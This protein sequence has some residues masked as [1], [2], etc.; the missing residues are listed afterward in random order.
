MRYKL[1]GKHTGLRVS[2]LVL[3]AGNFGTR[4][5]HGAEPDE[6]RRIFDAYAEAGGNFIDTANG[7]QFGQSEEI[8]GDLLAGKRDD[9]VLATKFTMRTDPTSGILTTGNSRKSM[10][11]SV[12]ASLKRLK[13]DRVDVLWAH[14][15]D[16]VTP[17]EELVRGFDD[18]VRAGKVLYAGLSDFPAWRV[19]R[20]ATI[21]ELRGVAPIAGLQVE[22]SLVER[23]TEQELLP[24][25]QALGLGVVAWSPLGG[26]MLT[27]KYRQGEKGRAEGFGGRVFQAENSAQRTAILDTLIAVAKDAGVTPAEI[28]IAWV[29]SKGSLPVIGPRT[30]AQLE[31]NL[32]A[33]NVTL[34]SEQIARLDEVSA[35]PPVFPYTLLSDPENQQGFT[36]GKLDLFDAPAQVVA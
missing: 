32:S 35:L 11:S 4:W 22:H 21:A 18:L 2:E 7:Y 1:F 24:A 28:A 10:I 9:F 30:V 34:S 14:M 3:G 8:L 29:A 26:G 19:A 13:T 12:E 6:A 36:G 33:A 23:T 25:G 5:G 17:V 31:N 27:G 15:S 16:G 20:A